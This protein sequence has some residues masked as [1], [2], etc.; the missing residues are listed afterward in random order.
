MYAVG[1]YGNERV[2]SAARLH[3]FAARE[4]PSLPLSRVLFFYI[5]LNS[6]FTPELKEFTSSVFRQRLNTFLLSIGERSS[7]S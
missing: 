3:E 6:C 2:H 1:M 7:G 4:G 5:L